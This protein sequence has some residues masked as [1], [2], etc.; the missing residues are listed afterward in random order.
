M[1]LYAAIP[2]F[3]VKALRRASWYGGSN[4]ASGSGMVA[5]PVPTRKGSEA[6]PPVRFDDSAVNRGEQATGSP[7]LAPR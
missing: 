4:T 2:C 6:V 7:V 5:A 1:R 3:Q